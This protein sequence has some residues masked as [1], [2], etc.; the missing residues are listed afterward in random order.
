M[1]IGERCPRVSSRR[2]EKRLVSCRAYTRVFSFD[3]P[4]RGMTLDHLSAGRSICV[5][6]NAFR[7]NNESKWRALARTWINVTE[8]IPSK[9]QHPKHFA[10]IIIRAGLDSA[11]IIIFTADARIVYIVADRVTNYGRVTIN[12]QSTSRAVTVE[13]LA[14]SLIDHAEMRY[15]C[16]NY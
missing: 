13:K 10:I 2:R 12:F 5:S 6:I 14:A 9:T 16:V 4:V 7:L 3:L 1:C 11:R 15:L 8:S